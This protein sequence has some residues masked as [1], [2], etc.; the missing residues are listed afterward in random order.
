MKKPSLS[1]K[2][3]RAQKQQHLT[4]LQ[5]FAALE[6]FLPRYQVTGIRDG[7]V[8]T[9]R[10]KAPWEDGRTPKG[11][12]EAVQVAAARAAGVRIPLAI[13]E[14]EEEYRVPV[15]EAVA[16]FE[17][18]DLEPFLSHLT[19]LGPTLLAEPQLVPYLHGWWYWCR[20]SGEAGDRARQL[21]KRMGS[22]LADP[23]G[24][25]DLPMEKREAIVADYKKWRPI[26]EGLNKDFKQ[27]WKARKARTPTNSDRE[28]FREQM[29][30]KFK[31]DVADVQAIEWRLAKPSQKASKRTPTEAICHIV[32]REH[33]GI[34]AK[35]VEDVWRDYLKVHPEE[36]RRR[37][38]A[39]TTFSVDERTA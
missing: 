22:V 15:E 24:H 39:P 18:G 34:G 26:C 17:R 16:G 10:E 13:A 3:V 33:P 19:L 11:A 7:V 20:E 5:F 25:P 30:K 28:K 9:A 8:Q 29:A 35:A 23:I 12:V 14:L 21:F 27:L 31:I 1:R 36:R 4:H 6:P 38:K 2:V 37:Q 32:A